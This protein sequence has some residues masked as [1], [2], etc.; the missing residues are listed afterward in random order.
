[1]TKNVEFLQNE[2]SRKVVF[3]GKYTAK[4]GGDIDL[5]KFF[6]YA[7]GGYNPA[8]SNSNKVTFYLFID[9]EEVADT[10]TVNN[11]GNVKSATTESFSD[12][13]VKA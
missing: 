12:I 9:G 13:R 3:D 6:I 5:N 8:A 10:T 2:T 4:K 11:T 7:D 1:L